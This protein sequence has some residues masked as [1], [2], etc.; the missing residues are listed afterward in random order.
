MSIV[1]RPKIDE[2]SKFP[3]IFSSLFGDEFFDS[4]KNLASC[5]ERPRANITK[6][7]THYQIDISL[8]GYMQDDIDID[9]KENTLT[10]SSNIETEEIESITCEFSITSF[11]RQ[12][13]LPK[14]ANI[15]EI[16]AKLN[17]GILSITIPFTKD[18]ARTINIS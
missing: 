8:A 18:S 15:E 7:D 14:H 4:N 3:S 1:S 17:D 13:S 10:I 6:T 2:Y 16:S 5:N 11:E 9:V 12:W